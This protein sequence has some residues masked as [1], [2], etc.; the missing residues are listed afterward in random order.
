MKKA[1]EESKKLEDQ[2]KAQMEEEEEM[3]RKAIEA[4]KQEAE[5][6]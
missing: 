2:Q 3:I 6:H 4:S 1:L 5:V